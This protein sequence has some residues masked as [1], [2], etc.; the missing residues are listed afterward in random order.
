MS[1]PALSK[2]FDSPNCALVNITC[3]DSAVQ[4]FLFLSNLSQEIEQMGFAVPFWQRVSSVEI[5]IIN[6]I[7]RVLLNTMLVMCKNVI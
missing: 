4:S 7:I 5:E 6:L 1:L 3:S 2:H